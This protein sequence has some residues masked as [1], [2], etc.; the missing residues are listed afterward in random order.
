[1]LP[2]GRGEALRAKRKRLPTRSSW[3]L[4]SETLESRTLLAVME[5]GYEELSQEW[6]VTTQADTEAVNAVQSD[7]DEGGNG[8]GCPVCGTAF[9]VT[10]LDASGNSYAELSAIPD[11]A[12][13]TPDAEDAVP[14]HAPLADTF[15]LHSRPS[16]TK[17]IYLDFTGH[18]TT[19]TAWKG[20][21][22]L[23]T[24]PYSIDGNSSFS[25]IELHNIQ[26]IWS[27]VVED[28]S[29]FDV[30]VTT[31]E[32]AI[33]D[34]RKAGSGDHRWGI[35]VV[36]GKNTW[37]SG[38][39]GVAYLGSF[40]WSS[41]TPCFVFPEL[42][43]NSNKNI[44][45][46]TSHEIGHALGLRHDGGGGD[47]DYYRG[48]GSGATSWAPIM[49]A[50]YGK[51]I[52]H[53]SKGEYKDANNQEDDL[54]IIVGA[55]TT[56]W[57]PNG[58][59]FG[60]RSD[61]F[62]NTIEAAYEPV[63]S[64]E[65]VASANVAGV[66]ERF[67]DVD[68]FKFFTSETLQATINPAPV[69]PSLDILAKI[70]DPAG[71]VLF[72]SNPFESL[73]ASFSQT[74]AAG[75]YYLS[76]EGTGKGDVEGTGYSDY[77][78]LGQYGIELTVSG[79]D[80]PEVQVL[81]GLDSIADDTGT[82]SFGAIPLG[83]SATK[84]FTVNN[85]GTSELVVQPVSVTGDFSVT[86]NLTASAVVPVGGS[87]SF[88]VRFNA[89]SLG[90][91]SG[92]VSFANNDS[93]ESPFDF[94]V[95]GV[96][97]PPPA[98]EVQVR[99]G[100]GVISDGTGLVD[101]GR[102]PVGGSV[103][104]L[105]TVE[106]V[107]LL[108]L[109]VQPV[110]IPSGFTITNNFEVDQIIAAGQSASFEIGYK[111]EG[112]GG[113]SGTVSFANSDA[114]ENPF[115]FSVAGEGFVPPTVQVVDDGDEGFEATGV[116]GYGSKSGFAGDHRYNIAGKHVDEAE[117]LALVSPG[118]YRVSA[119]WKAGTNRA[120]NAAFATFDG[121]RRLGVV[122]I[123]QE[124]P[125][126]DFVDAGVMWEDIGGVVDVRGHELSVRLN[127]RADQYVIADAIRFERVGD[128]PP[129]AA[130]VEVYYAERKLVD[131]ISELDYGRVTPGKPVSKEIVVA[132]SGTANLV[133]QPV[134]VPTGFSVIQNVEADTVI[135]PG[136]NVTVV[137][138]ADATSVGI[139]SGMLSFLNSDADESV[140]DFNLA[141]RVAYP[142][143]IQILDDGSERF[144][145]DG[146]SW[147][148]AAKSGFH[149]D[150]RY[151][152]AGKG[153]NEATW[154]FDVVPGIYQVAAT[155]L[156]G[157][158]RA[159]NASYSVLNEAVGLGST[160]S[161][162][163][164]YVNQENAP[165]DFIDAGVPWEV[166]GK[167][168]VIEGS[169]LTVVLSDNANQYVIAD[170]I[171]IERLGD[172]PVPGPEIVVVHAGE[173]VADETGAVDFG[174]TS[175][176]K[177][178]SKTFKV[179]NTG[180]A[181]LTVQPITVPAGFT[182]TKNFA[183]DTVIAPGQFE[184]FVVEL[185]AAADGIYSG[186]LAF[187]STDSDEGPY[188]FSI[189][190][191]VAPPSDVQ[192]LDDSEE[193]FY[194]S[195][196]WG[197]GNRSG[198]QGGHRWTERG[199]GSDEATWTFAVT[200]G[201]YRV[202]ATWKAGLNRATNAP[203]TIFDDGALLSTVLVNQEYWPK[204]LFANDRG[205][206]DL[207]LPHV[208]TGTELTVRLTDAANEY[209]IA[210]A[211]RI[212]RLGDVPV[213]RPEIAVMHE[214]ESVLD[215]T[216][217]IEF[218][219]TSSGRPVSK[220]FWVKN[221]GTADLTVQPIS[222][223][224]GFSLTKN[225]APN[226]VIPPGQYETFVVELDALTDGSYSGELAFSS[227]DADESPYNF[228]V[229]G[230]V[231][232]PPEVQVLDDSDEGF[233]ASGRWTIGTRSGY[234][235]GHQWTSKGV[236][237]DEATWTFTVTPGVYRVSAT[238]KAG[239]NRATN[240][241]FTVSDDGAAIS[242]V[243]INQ[244]HAPKDLFANDRGW[245]DIGHTGLW[246]I[247]GT[248]L[249]V[250]L[251]DAADEYVIADAIRVQ[252]LGD[253]PPG[254]PEVSVIHA[255]RLVADGLGT[256]DFGSAAPGGPISKEFTVRNVGQESLTVQP[257]TAPDGF[258]VTSN[259]S[260][261]TVIAPGQSATFEV[262]LDAVSTGSFAGELSFAN[263]DADE[264]P[265][266]FTV[267]GIVAVPPAVQVLDN[268]SVGFATEGHWVHG[269]KSGYHRDHHYSAKGVGD[270]KATWRFT[271]TP[272]TYRVSATWKAGWNRASNSP[273]TVYDGASPFE[274]IR[275]NQRLTPSDLLEAEVGWKDIGG[276]YAVT[277]TSLVVSLTDAA[278][279]YVIADA[280]RIERI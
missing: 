264:N 164:H 262:T 170:A 119:T 110:S 258:S 124:L 180:T 68:V 89:T 6:V 257:I 88:D 40:N 130:E 66:I 87:L 187:V 45:M 246:L 100:E 203:F 25:D 76:V 22:T 37:G 195:G 144:S 178:I 152:E 9:C 242:T 35:R 44:A 75:Y 169:V 11:N 249:T 62:G 137:I 48:H 39:A 82:V 133:V 80:G 19:G 259:F 209:V 255:G 276:L 63:F 163:M 38:G 238:W 70:L 199:D 117:W 91:Y 36:I 250:T 185:D 267:S 248:E 210:D 32:P 149:G 58:N 243:L 168:Y 150:H 158:N 196:R 232:A 67:S 95:T 213:P 72:Q 121:D 1:M 227:T 237:A 131:G 162:G 20:G 198:Y 225:F 161:V 208:I 138:Q 240:A 200:P 234:D 118:R 153:L 217:S 280:I 154:T 251:T 279:N 59:G 186:E 165:N 104:R 268:A 204:D 233:H 116:W 107:G 239:L 41:D 111:A 90:A 99:I 112:V 254:T 226:T 260:V 184:T 53:W 272:G 216:G 189:T 202:S 269:K 220:T 228:V 55:A 13:I 275:V 146:V 252:R 160:P 182:L 96:V 77:G 266:N 151:I 33:D 17:T 207:G 47:G 125:P 122:R 193:G 218:G 24:P 223:P 231:A 191:M 106:N 235:G 93:N 18:T 214:G 15:L 274:T 135:E 85:V 261:D 188:N 2:H 113:V 54:A 42:L 60:Y 71:Q 79:V 192:I 167:A 265:F 29:P 142:A 8:G 247:T 229:S 177:T 176:G 197:V 143:D 221:I 134:N 145:A 236:G 64:E 230:V 132:N 278:D 78:S 241:P 109:M 83:M 215:D 28:F 27:R 114:D 65:F 5:A 98:P 92:T 148:L 173:E 127:D 43:G 101:F 270:N 211:I 30:D 52:H 253:L 102:I 141:S 7:E 205:W 74:V 156:P 50:G 271:V 212:E 46:A 219:R 115:D 84:T 190:G 155:W 201:R 129:P 14:T 245:K 61:D 23:V 51:S 222:V 103:K 172:V 224:D 277:G 128:L 147:K 108:D 244:E 256:I 31:E 26:N 140:F 120:T 97:E 263:S 174:R 171:R 56:Q 194:A 57:T 94:T 10:H 34:L 73:A 159:T 181:G 179:E 16:A 175:S 166:I 69:G 21:D 126:D 4:G 49:G 136:Q 123:N 86:S 273:F 139:Y 81:D 3:Q 12:L 105:F 206:K 157:I 183:S